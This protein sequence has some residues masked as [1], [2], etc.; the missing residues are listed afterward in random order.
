MINSHRGTCHHPMGNVVKKT[1]SLPAALAREAE[2]LARAEGKT[3]SAVVQDALRQAHLERRLQELRGVQGFWSR[4]A[5]D[6]GILTEQDLE[7]YLT[8]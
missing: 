8:A 1:I 5:R 4:K 6:K 2:A 7:R 3:L